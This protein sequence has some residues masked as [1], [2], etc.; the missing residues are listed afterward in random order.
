VVRGE[1]FSFEAP[2]DWT[3]VRDGN[4]TAVAKGAVDRVEVS[5]FQLVKPYR[6]ALFEAAARE[7]DGVASRLA[8]QQPG[9]G[10]VVSS[11]T[12]R[13]AGRKARAYRIEYSGKA[14]ELIFV[15]KGRQE[16]LLTCRRDAAGDDSACT[17]LVETFA[18]S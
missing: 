3:V 13:A 5:V 18:L 11:E 10:R 6:P 16:Y 15:L 4:V 7:L 1:G 14:L 17:Q 2:A 8:K 9:Q 12:V